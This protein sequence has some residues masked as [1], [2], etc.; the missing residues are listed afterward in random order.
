MIKAYFIGGSQDLTVR[1]LQEPTR[2][3]K[4]PIY[5]GFEASAYRVDDPCE[6]F[7]YT[8]EQYVLSHMVTHDVAVYVPQEMI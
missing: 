7:R 4:F 1:A 5:R 6:A 3:M 8:E 2:C